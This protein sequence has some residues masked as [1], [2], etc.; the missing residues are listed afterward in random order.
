M[1]R[2]QS[3]RLRRAFHLA[4]HPLFAVPLP[5]EG[6]QQGDRR[7]ELLHERCG[8][9]GMRLG[10]DRL[11]LMRHDRTTLITTGNDIGIAGFAAPSVAPG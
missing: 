8:D 6:L 1:E 3:S 2:L 11:W 10:A 9:G 4:W 5:H 7:V